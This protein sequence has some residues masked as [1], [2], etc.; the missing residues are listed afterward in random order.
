MNREEL[1]KEA[2]E[3]YN[4]RLKQN[5]IKSEY[6]NQTY[7][8]GYIDGAEPRERYIE[9]LKLKIKYLTQHLEP[10]VMTALFEQIEEEVK[11]EQKVKELETQVAELN[12][13]IKKL[14][15]D[16]D[17]WYSAENPPKNNME[18]VIAEDNYGDILMAWYCVHKKIWYDNECPEPDDEITVVRWKKLKI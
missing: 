11:H 9:E 6:R 13:T 18:Q 1:E 3:K 15:I 7:N 8:D 10:Q 2:E 4:E 16:F 17:T 12:E 5:D 14:K